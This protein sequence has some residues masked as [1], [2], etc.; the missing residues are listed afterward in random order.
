MI[1]LTNDNT[2]K[3]YQKAADAREHW[4]HASALA[5]MASL[6]IGAVSAMK[7]AKQEFAKK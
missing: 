2:V 6:A 1:N 4:F 3:A 7:I 5:F